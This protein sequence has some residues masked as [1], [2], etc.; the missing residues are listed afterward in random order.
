[1]SWNYLAKFGNGNF[2]GS[3]LYGNRLKTCV[4]LDWP[5]FRPI[6]GKPRF[7]FCRNLEF[8]PWVF[9]FLIE[10]W[11]PPLS[12]E[13]FSFNYGQFYVNLAIFCLKSFSRKLKEKTQPQGGTFL[14]LKETQEKNSILPKIKFLWGTTFNAIFVN[15]YFQFSIIFITNIEIF[16]KFTKT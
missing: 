3:A 13:F 4:G 12:F 6:F 9:S 16:R 7:W 5:F 2:F 11:V 15:K 10:F 8:F 1:M 14:F